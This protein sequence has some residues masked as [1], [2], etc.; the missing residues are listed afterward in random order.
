MAAYMIA[1]VDVHD[2]AG[3][4]AYRE[5]AG[6]TTATY[7]AKILAAFGKVVHLE[8]DWQPKNLV[9][10]EF[11]TLEQAER[12]YHSAEYGKAIPLR[13]QSTTSSLAIA[14]GLQ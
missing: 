6:P 5:V 10:L 8:G 1:V 13:Q 14:E 7:N 3:F 11:E 9:L 2:A 4:D 12:W